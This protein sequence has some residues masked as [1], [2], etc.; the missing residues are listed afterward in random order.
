MQQKRHVAVW[1]CYYNNVD[2]NWLTGVIQNFI[3]TFYFMK[4]GDWHLQHRLEIRSFVVNELPE[5]GTFLSKH[6]A[7]GT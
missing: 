6:T 7:V 1:W 3:E 4:E 5:D 2:W